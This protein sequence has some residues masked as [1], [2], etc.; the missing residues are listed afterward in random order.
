MWPWTVD[1]LLYDDAD[2]DTDDDDSES[3]SEEVRDDRLIVFTPEAFLELLQNAS[4]W[5]VDGTFQEAP[6]LVTQLYTIHEVSQ[7]YTC[8]RVCM[9]CC[10]TSHDR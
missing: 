3:E 4:I 2:G 5:I 10:Q 8:S 1:F 7:D 9:C 6:R